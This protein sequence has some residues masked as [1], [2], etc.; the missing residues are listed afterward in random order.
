MMT[1]ICP[2]PSV[3]SGPQRRCHLL[4]TLCLPGQ[5]VTPEYISRLNGVD[6]ALSRQDIADAAQA[7]RRYHRLKLLTQ[8]DGSYTIEGS[9]L[10][11]RLC[12]MYWLR[13]SLRLCPH[14]VHQQFTPALKTALKQPGI[15]RALYDDINLQALINLCA[16]RLQRVFSTPERQFLHLFLPWCLLQHQLGHIPQFTAVQRGWTLQ[17][18]EAQVAQE[19]VRHWRRRVARPPHDNELHFLTALFMLLHTPSVHNDSAVHDRKLLA[20]VDA[21]IARFHSLCGLTFSC[22]A[23]LREQLYVHLAQ[24]LNRSVFG[25]GIDS[26]LPQEITHL[27]PRLMRTTREAIKDL[28]AE[29]NIRFSSEETGLIAII[30]GAW[31]MQESALEEKQVLLLTGNDPGLEEGLEQQ[32]RELTLLPLSVRRLSLHAFQ[33]EGA[34]KEVALI[35]TPYVTSLPLFSPPLIHLTLPAGEH[36]LQRIREI[37]ES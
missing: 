4:L 33:R 20:A 11:R 8:P 34:P 21:L 27:Y 2:P 23:R 28:E 10:D 5:D 9:A 22:E 16:R 13:R 37:L 35:V 36:Q 30:F 19:I 1:Q 32:L 24:A 17:R 18:H 15:A 12:L 7:L 26:S 6:D 29:F 3:L 14:Y 25:I 31:L